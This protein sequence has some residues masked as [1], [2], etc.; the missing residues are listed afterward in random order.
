[1][2][3][4]FDKIRFLQEQVN[5]VFPKM[6]LDEI[7][8]I[9]IFLS[10]SWQRM[11]TGKLTRE[12]GNANARCALRIKIIAKIRVLCGILEPPEAVLETSPFCYL[13]VVIESKV[14]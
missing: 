5:L 7:N 1:M 2:G 13:L 3:N 14:L 8:S 10:N 12:R 11:K 4:V 6:S 9:V